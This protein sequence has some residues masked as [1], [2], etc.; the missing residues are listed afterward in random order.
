MPFVI[1][2]TQG[3]NTFAELK[4]EVLAYGFDANAYSTRV[5]NW[6]NEAQARIARR[7]NL[8]ELA[9]TTTVTTVAGTTAYS[10][11]GDFIRVEA[12]IDQT[13]G[14]SFLLD[15]RPAE[16]LR[17]LSFSGRPQYYSLGAEGL[18]VW[19]NPDAAYTLE[20]RYFKNP[21]QM[22][23]DGDVPGIPGD[24]H[25]L[26]VSYALSRAYRSEDDAQMSTFHYNEFM[27][28]L[29]QMAADRQDNEMAESNQIAG[30]YGPRGGWGDW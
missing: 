15:P 30:M 10:L 20:A 29:L 27:R 6:L 18:L 25:D 8:R 19:P 16:H 11:P 17:D 26:L 24:Y 14:N 3:G 28:D 21:P 9:T 13:S 2:P 4:T 12:V 5:G 7:L 22:S 1:S 23:A